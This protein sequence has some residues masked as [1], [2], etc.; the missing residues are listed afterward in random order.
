MTSFVYIRVHRKKAIKAKCK[1]DHTHWSTFASLQTTLLS[2]KQCAAVM[3]CF[4][5]R[6]AP[7]QLTP[8]SPVV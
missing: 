3:M 6:T 5:D 8:F 2:Q 1:I 7:V 4:S